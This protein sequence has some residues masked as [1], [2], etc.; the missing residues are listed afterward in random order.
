[1]VQNG[2]KFFVSRETFASETRQFD[3]ETT[4]ELNGASNPLI[5]RTHAIQP[6]AAEW[7]EYNPKG[8]DQF[9]FDPPP[10]KFSKM[11]FDDV[12]AVGFLAQRDLSQGRP[13]A[14]GLWNL[15][16]GCGEPIALKY[17]AFQAR[18]TIHRPDGESANVPLVPVGGEPGKPAL[19]AGKTEVTF[20]QWVRVA[21]WA[22]TNQRASNFPENLRHLAI[23]GYAFF[24]DGAL[25][26]MET[27]AAGPFLLAEPVT[28]VT[29][30]DAA[31]WC[32]AL[33]E[34]EGLAPAYY[35]DAAMT[36]PFRRVLERNR[37][38]TAD[39]RAPIH[40]NKAAAGY[41][42]PTRS[43][44]TWL[45]TFGA[46]NAPAAPSP[47]TAWIA[48][49]SGN[50][51][52]P[53]GA[54]PA[55]AAGLHDLFGNVAEWIWDGDGPF[56]P[57]ASPTLAALGGSYRF[58]EDEN[59]KGAL[60]FPYRPA[61]GCPAIGFRVVKNSAGGTTA[62]GGKVPERQIS[63]AL[64]VPPAAP[65]S[66]KAIAKIAE[67]TLRL[68]AIPNGGTLE[69]RADFR[70]TPKD[71]PAYNVAA[72][73]VEIPYALWNPVRQ[74]AESEKGYRF[75]QRG[76]MGSLRLI[77]PENETAPRSPDEPVTHIAWV[78]AVTW[79]NA[80]SELLGLEPV[81]RHPNGDVLRLAPPFR[82]ET[83]ERYH[84][85]NVGPYKD[86]EVDTAAVIDWEVRAGANGFRLPSRAE[87]EPLLGPK[88]APDQGWFLENAG[89]KTHPVATRQPGHAGLFDVH[90]NAAEM[91]LGGSGLFGQTRLG[92][93]FAYPPGGQPHRAN[94]Q[95]NPFVARSYL[96]F[97][98]VRRN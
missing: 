27:G 11:A 30:A 66:P 84:Y 81:F 74:W 63:A 37:W 83:Y 55:N 43:E 53:T 89:M 51:T 1:M 7:A 91:L 62:A 59:A 39:L 79:C 44:W 64:R 41:R 61:D 82:V 76:D 69:D 88:P 97:R 50:R 3:L 70:Q 15:P 73:A 75:N 48:A 42:L 18:A 29:F 20:A 47:D 56:D 38:E 77:L 96:G 57:A 12:Q 68:T 19:W 95:E 60:P 25:G 34:L 6:A 54:K 5:K 24:R 33:S 21:R 23:P 80:L 16:H 98:P 26:N 22:A 32:N 87:I 14:G 36:I 10:A 52:H 4:G 13:V 46:N 28:G 71:G 67:E 9:F 86:R 58:P 93:C 49:N 72:A 78:D 90:G 45:A 92:G 65:A 2:G 31:A 17:N 35:A 85:A 94:S 40:W 8:P